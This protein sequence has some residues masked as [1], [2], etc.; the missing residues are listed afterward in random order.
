MDAMPYYVAHSW[1][2][3][4]HLAT[5]NISAI[6]HTKTSNTSQNDSVTMNQFPMQMNSNVLAQ[7]QQ[8]R[9]QRTIL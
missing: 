1:N 7:L 2:L 5:S 3:S 8:W 6:L 9:H 4:H